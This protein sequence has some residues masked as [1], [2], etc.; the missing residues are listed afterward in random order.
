MPTGS[1][2]G[3][4]VVAVWNAGLGRYPE[5]M[6]QKAARPGMA[7]LNVGSQDIPTESIRSFA[8][9]SGL[10]RQPP[11]SLRLAGRLQSSSMEPSTVRAEAASVG[12]AK[13]GFRHTMT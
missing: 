2:R 8:L 5:Y 1:T 13:E 10:L 3:A 6:P 12:P 4:I 11:P 7:P 9:K